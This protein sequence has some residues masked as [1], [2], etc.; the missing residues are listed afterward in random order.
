MNKF[1]DVTAIFAARAGI[2]PDADVVAD[3]FESITV[4]LPSDMAR[5]VEAAIKH[6]RGQGSLPGPEMDWKQFG[7]VITNYNRG[8]AIYDI[9]AEY[10]MRT[11]ND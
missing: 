6:R 9:C 2:T 5:V 1:T 10:V 11:L 4:I 3:D 8:R 7:P